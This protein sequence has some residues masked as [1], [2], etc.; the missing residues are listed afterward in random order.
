MQLKSVKPSIEKSNKRYAQVIHFSFLRDVRG[1]KAP[2]NKEKLQ[3]PIL[4]ELQ[5]VSKNLF[6]AAN[7]QAQLLF[8][9]RQQL[10]IRNVHFEQTEAQRYGCVSFVLFRQHYPILFLRYILLSICQ[11]CKIFGI[12]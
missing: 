4:A 3:C 7:P 6:T 5:K 11:T 2:I 12:Y 8:S 10:Q 1:H 9:S